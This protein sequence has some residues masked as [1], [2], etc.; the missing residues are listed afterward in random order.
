ARFSASTPGRR[1]RGLLA[2]RAG[3]ADPRRRRPPHLPPAA[4]ADRRGLGP[5]GLL[6]PRIRTPPPPPAALAPVPPRLRHH[7]ARR[8]DRTRAPGR[9]S[10]PHPGTPGTRPLRRPLPR[11]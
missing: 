11:R 2:V 10:P 9:R 5:G 8:L 3:P 1:R 6:G 4:H 7:R